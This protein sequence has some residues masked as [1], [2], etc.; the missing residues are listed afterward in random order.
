MHKHMYV[1]IYGL[2]MGG[3]FP[4]IGYIDNHYM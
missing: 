3:D 2:E 1:C 4:K